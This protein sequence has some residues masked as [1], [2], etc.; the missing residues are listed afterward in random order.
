MKWLPITNPKLT[1]SNKVRP[2]NKI[3]FALIYFLAVLLSVSCVS[4]RLLD[5]DEYLYA[6]A[7]VKVH[8]EEEEIKGLSKLEGLLEDETYPL[9]NRRV[10]GIP[11]KLWI[12]SV[13][14]KKEKKDGNFLSNTY[15][16]RPVLLSDVAEEEV[17]GSLQTV[18]KANGFLD[19]RV[20][21]EVVKTKFG[22]QQRKI[23]YH[24][25]VEPPYNLGK[26]EIAINDSLITHYVDSVSNKSLL[27]TGNRYNLQKIRDE[28][29]RIDELLK[30]KGYYYFSPDFLIFKADSSRKSRQIDLKLNIKDDIDPLYLK[31][32]YVNKVMVYDNSVRDS[33]KIADTVNYKGVNF[34]SGKLVKPK[35][36]RHFI[37]FSDSSLLTT[38][39]YTITNKNLSSLGIFKYA[40]LEAVPLENAKNMVNINVSL[41]PNSRN[42]FKASANLVSKSNDFAG[43]GVEL[44][45]RNRNLFGG[46]EQLIIQTT[47]NVE[48]WLGKSGKNV[49][50][51]YNY[52][53]GASAELK[54][55]RF[56]LL[57]P[58]VIS[59]KYIPDNHIRLESRYINQM[60]FYRMSFFRMLY[61][62]RWTETVFRNHE[63]NIVDITYQHML[64][65]T[66]SFDSLIRLNPLI[67]QS[68]SDQFIVGT[69][70]TYRY[71]VP[72]NDPRRLKTAFTGALDLSG[73]LL[74][75]L[76]ALFGKKST[77]SDTLKFLGNAYAQYVKT[78]VDYRVY[79]D[80]SKK[81][82]IATRLSAGLGLPVGN[83]GILPG[84]KQYYLGGANSIRAYRFR[85][86]GPG[87]YAVEKSK[88]VLI[89]H[90]G[91]IMLL[92]NIENRYK[93]TRSLEWALFIDA[94]NI[95]LARKDTL[96]TGAVFNSSKFLKELAIGWGTGIRYINQY[97]IIRVDVGFPIHS[98]NE[99]EKASDMD[100]IWN[101]AIGYPF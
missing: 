32:W 38:Q 43:P 6:G 33:M 80:V 91:E 52:E 45:Y 57:N 8:A 40:N 26:I 30:S 56:L 84:I 93:L 58:S 72:D 36:F 70:Y 64:K 59:S 44:S 73:N 54:F 10:L 31:P 16:E 85:S 2:R 23:L 78:T 62:Y 71:A 88:D 89:N 29:E 12:Y 65:S 61:G 83:S 87:A 60:Q 99:I 90:S 68:F 37:L 1:M 50:G 98:P 48:A 53:L 49:I 76:Q 13:F 100:T 69:N 86:V 81:N 92:G 14:N 19:S 51:D 39:D 67:R 66:N 27:R 79:F 74:Y 7:K 3:T 15:G 97:F 42:N 28:R 55:P 41:S 96:R 17:A 46:G 75:G 24:C 34:L 4:S 5:D 22:K 82:R 77:E 63:L 25:F 20:R 101:F 18:L 11:Y 94:G 47:G 21:S 95:W 9:P 35:Y